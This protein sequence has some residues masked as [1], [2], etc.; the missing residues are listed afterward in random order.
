MSYY[1]DTYLKSGH[2]QSLRSARLDHSNC[3][4]AI[5]GEISAKNDV[6][7]I[8]YAGSIWKVSVSDLRVLCRMCHSRVHEYEK[9]RPDIANLPNKQKWKEIFSALSD[10]ILKQRRTLRKK[11]KLDHNKRFDELWL[12][13]F[14][15]CV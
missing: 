13:V 3:Q 10:P 1:R 6:H 7:H 12:P 2:W 14:E 4:C 9:S 8:D 5:C 11:K 15:S